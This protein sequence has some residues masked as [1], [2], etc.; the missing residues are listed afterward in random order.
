MLWPYINSLRNC[1]SDSIQ[2]FSGTP[3]QPRV[4]SGFCSETLSFD[5]ALSWNSQQVSAS[6]GLQKSHSAPHSAWE[7]LASN[8]KLKYQL[9]VSHKL[10]GTLPVSGCMQLSFSDSFRFTPNGWSTL[11]DGQSEANHS[12][13]FTRRSWKRLNCSIIDVSHVLR[14][15]HRL[16]VQC[17][18]PV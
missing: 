6:G 1:G 3:C 17:G 10:Q 11:C 14:E 18:I 7:S 2:N 13:N 9:K 4:A 15:H 5:L 12:M 8:S 16:R